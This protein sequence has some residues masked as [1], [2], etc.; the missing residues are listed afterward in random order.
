MV[1]ILIYSLTLL[2]LI[3]SS[4]YIWRTYWMYNVVN[5]KTDRVILALLWLNAFLILA[6]FS[7]ILFEYLSL[8]GIKLIS[9]I[10]FLMAALTTAVLAG[11]IKR[12]PYKTLKMLTRQR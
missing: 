9:D 12:G 6:T 11:E 1:V 3:Y 4:T 5:K 10:S 2:V 8:A 7:N